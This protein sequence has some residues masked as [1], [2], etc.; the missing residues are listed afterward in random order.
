MF[1]Y[2]TEGG[3]IAF[4]QQ[5]DRQTGKTPLQLFMDGRAQAAYNYEKFELW[6][7]IKTG[8]PAAT[9]AYLAGR[10]LS[11]ADFIE[12]GKWI[13]EQM[14]AYEVWV[15]L[16][17]TSQIPNQLM[18][19]EQ[20]QDVNFVFVRGLLT[21]SNWKVAYMDNNQQLFVNDRTDKGK[22]LMDD[23]RKGNA[24]FPNELSM[25]LTLAR[26][27]LHLKDPKLSMQGL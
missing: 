20:L 26:N 13:D 9:S 2:W 11:D 8:G 3:A 5:P 7:N 10:K 18:S 15:I 14:E 17:P 6:R 23:I 16:M 27:F 12:I 19:S 1:N 21:R 24:K 25:N 22:M 4:G